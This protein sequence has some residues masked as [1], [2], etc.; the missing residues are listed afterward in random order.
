MDSAISI[1]IS[2][3]ISLLVYLG[4][5]YALKNPKTEISICRQW[6]FHPNVVCVWRVL[7]G[8]IG[9][10]LYLLPLLLALVDF[11]THK[12]ENSQ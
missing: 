2:L 9:I 7:I 12:R 6:I 3:L 11:I 4:F 5:L 1:T 10:I 8:F